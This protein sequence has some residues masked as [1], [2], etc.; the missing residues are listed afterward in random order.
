MTPERCSNPVDALGRGSWVAQLSCDGKIRTRAAAE[1]R[2]PAA[3]LTKRKPGN[4]RALRRNPAD[5]RSRNFVKQVCFIDG[6]IVRGGEACVPV[7]D[8]GLQRGYAV[9]DYART[10]RGRLFHAIDHIARLRRSAAA[11][12]LSLPY[13]DEEVLA[14]AKRLIE[15]LGEKE[16]GLRMILTG[17]SAHAKDLLAHARFILIA[18]E[19][20]V[21]PVEIY[22]KGVKLMTHEFERDL[23]FVKSTNYL[24]GFRLIPEKKEKGAFEVL[25][26]WRGRLLECS[27]D[28]FFVFRGDVLATPGDYVLGGIT[29]Q[30]LLSV[31]RARFR[32]EERDVLVDEVDE[33]DEAF[34]ASTSKQIVPVIRID[35]H[36]IG[37]GVVGERTKE[38]MALFQDYADRYR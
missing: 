16:A 25:Y 12:H 7:D 36:M 6:K 11:L 38:A 10:Y 15:E 20:P 1:K 28:N 27:R 22:E 30:V 18:E 17:G 5:E 19:L 9:F 14:T 2:E 32:V 34:L 29:R 24:T 3:S 31:A 4:R 8:L 33:I 37:R 13:S 35:D 21:Y 23:P 26:C